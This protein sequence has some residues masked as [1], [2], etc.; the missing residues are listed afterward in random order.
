[1]WFV[2]RDIR[3]I[4]VFDFDEINAVNGTVEL[5]VEGLG[6]ERICWCITCPFSH[7]FHNFKAIDALSERRTADVS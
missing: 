4:I 2:R 3:D 7:S 6:L 5:L 1:M